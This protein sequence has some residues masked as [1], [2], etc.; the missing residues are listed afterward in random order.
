MELITSV[1][2]GSG[3][4]ASVTLPG[5][6][7]IPAT[8]TDLKMV[9]SARATVA[10]TQE[11]IKISFNGNTSNYALR[12]L[13]GDGGATSSNSYSQQW[14][15]YAVG[16]TA[17]DSTFSNGEMYI[18]NYRS[19]NFKSFAN[20][21]V[22]E[23]NNSN[24]QSLLAANLWSDTAAIT[25]IELTMQGGSNFVEGSIFS[26]YGISSVTSTP[27]AT[28]GT[29]SQDNSYWYHT[30]TASG[31]FTLNTATNCDY[32][33]IAGGGGGGQGGGGAGGLRAFTSQSLSA[34]NYTVT[35]GAGAATVSK[36]GNST[37]NSNSV[38]G[39]GI[40][41]T[42]TTG[43]TGGS[44]GGGFNGGA[45]GA[46]NEGSYTP[47][48]GF[49]GGTGN[50]QGGGGGG[51]RGGVGGNAGAVNNSGG[52]GGPGVDT[53]SSW[54][55]VTFTGDNGYYAGGG[56]GGGSS[57]NGPRGVGGGGEGE[58]SGIQGGTSG[59]NNTGGGGGGGYLISSGRGGS[60][61]VIVRYAK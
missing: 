7:T 5:T 29:V 35:V 26:L 37:F 32:L 11:F 49:N 41:T 48:E 58:I 27:K 34:T 56:G 53:Y 60:G 55:T 13:Q 14:I 43:G 1:T 39:G 25:T 40:G 38:T 54:A 15:G 10:G 42:G 6:G 28:G 59:M 19:A 57:T 45:G 52:A 33:I 61:L 3:G 36:G 31:V 50:S 18:P 2:V 21:N 9:Y 24:A 20:D 16:S 4:A 23:R 30:F 47:V 12:T 51:G 17:T 46:G 22:A 44:G 8:Y